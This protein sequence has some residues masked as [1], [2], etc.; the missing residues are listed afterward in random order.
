MQGPHKKC[1]KK[2][3]GR[4]LRNEIGVTNVWF[5]LYPVGPTNDRDLFT[6]VTYFILALD[7]IFS[8]IRLH[9]FPFSIWRRCPR[10]RTDEEQS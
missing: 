7:A 6:A 10:R 4:A 3:A 1:V 2:I 5:N 9:P 8:L